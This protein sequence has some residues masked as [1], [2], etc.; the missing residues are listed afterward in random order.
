MR[1]PAGTYPLDQATTF[2]LGS[3]LGRWVGAQHMNPEVVIG[4]DTRESGPWIAAHVAGGLTL[5]R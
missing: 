2:A 4:M 3:A 5:A 1:G